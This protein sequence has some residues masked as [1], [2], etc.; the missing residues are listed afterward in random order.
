MT[1]RIIGITGH[2]PHKLQG[3]YDHFSFENKMLQYVLSQK[4][5]K[6]LKKYNEVVCITGMALGVDMLFAMAVIELKV[7]YGDR[8]KLIGA[9]PFGNQYNSWSKAHKVMWEMILSNCNS[10]VN[11]S[12]QEEVA[13]HEVSR[14]MQKRNEWIVDSCDELWAVWD[15]SRSGTGNCI[16]YAEKNNKSV[17]QITTGL[18]NKGEK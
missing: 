15:G 9:I 2:R 14:I 16:T 3:G 7:T 18:K 11:T 6:E 4:L 12:M 5:E 1:R 8:I 13:V 10:V 17:T